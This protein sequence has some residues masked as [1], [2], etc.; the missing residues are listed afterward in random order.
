MQFSQYNDQAKGLD[1]RGS[2]LG[3][4]REYS[5]R[6]RIQTGSGARP[7]SYPMRTRDYFTGDKTAGA[8]S[9]PLTS[10]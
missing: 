7:A 1:G 5:L 6:H 10:I 8:W 9:W 3:R 2:I 4:G